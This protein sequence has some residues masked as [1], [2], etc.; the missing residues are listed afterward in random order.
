MSGTGDLRNDGSEV[1]L[2]VRLAVGTLERVDTLV[3]NRPTRIPRHSWLLEAIHEKLNREERV[4]GILQVSREDNAEGD[5]PTGYVLRFLRPDRKKGRPVSLMTV[6]GNDCL[7]RYLVEWSVTSENA[8]AWIQKL[9]ANRSISIP[10]IVISSDRVGRYGF[11]VPPGG[12]HLDLGDDREAYVIPDHPAILPDGKMGDRMAVRT[13]EGEADVWL[14]S[15]GNVL[16]VVEE[17]I[18]PPGE[19]LGTVKITYRE[20]SKAETHEIMSIYRRCI[21][22]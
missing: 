3:K 4:E 12:I 9:K 20:A 1:P 10:D 22:D 13:R 11:K 5:V 18:W 7:E 8:R 14:T 21:L 2:T 17:H 19:P 6:V 15:D 16:V